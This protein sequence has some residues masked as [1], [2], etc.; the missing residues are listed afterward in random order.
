MLPSATS[1]IDKQNVR[2]NS[3][4]DVIAWICLEGFEQTS[5]SIKVSFV[6]KRC[7]SSCYA[8][9]KVPRQEPKLALRKYLV[10]AESLHDLLSIV[11]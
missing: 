3:T 8:Y 10:V 11:P 1:S 6:V 2:S 5:Q 9:L 4:A 7:L